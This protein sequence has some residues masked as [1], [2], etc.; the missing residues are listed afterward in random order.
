MRKGLFLMACTAGGA[1]LGFRVVDSYREEART[2][3]QRVVQRIIE[4]EKA[5]AGGK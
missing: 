3:K 4:E 1:A 2:E 5:R